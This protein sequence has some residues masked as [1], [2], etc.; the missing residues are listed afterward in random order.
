[1]DTSNDVIVDLN[2]IR[3]KLDYLKELSIGFIWV[4]SIKWTAEEYAD[5][6]EKTLDGYQSK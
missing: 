4:K 1:M 2:G 6:K 5:F 3:S